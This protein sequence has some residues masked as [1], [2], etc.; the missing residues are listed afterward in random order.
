MHDYRD[1]QRSHSVA[2]ARTV[3]EPIMIMDIW[4]LSDAFLSLGVMM[5]FGIV[6]DALMFMLFALLITLVFVP[7][8]KRK[9]RKGIFLHAPYRHAGMTLPGLAQ[10]GL[11]TEYS[12]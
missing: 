10:P 12:D 6:L 9:C 7:M 3:D 2:V 11:G 8:V 1:L 5:F 4:E